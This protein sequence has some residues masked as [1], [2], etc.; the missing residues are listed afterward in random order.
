MTVPSR[1]GDETAFSIQKIIY[2]IYFWINYTINNR[3]RRASPGRGGYALRTMRWTRSG[4]KGAFDL[5][6]AQ[7]DAQ[8]RRARARHPTVD[9]ASHNQNHTRFAVHPAH[10]PSKKRTAGTKRRSST[11]IRRGSSLLS[12]YSKVSRCARRQRIFL[13]RQ[14]RSFD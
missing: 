14:E 1:G 2:A 13:H 7:V 6:M 11:T 8:R 3:I 10:H 5:R 9:S 12:A 4:R